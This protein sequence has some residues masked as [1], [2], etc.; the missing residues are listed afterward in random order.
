MQILT[1]TF[2]LWTPAQSKTMLPN[3]VATV[4]FFYCDLLFSLYLT[5]LK[6]GFIAQSQLMEVVWGN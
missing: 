5:F 1:V 3:G 6:L 4:K 2:P